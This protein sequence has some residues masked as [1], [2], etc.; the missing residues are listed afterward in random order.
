M[1]DLSLRS[2]ARTELV[3]AQ[4]G[5][6]WEPSGRSRRIIGTTSTQ[7]WQHRQNW[8]DPLKLWVVAMHNST[9]PICQ[10]CLHDSRF[11]QISFLAMVENFLWTNR[12]KPSLAAQEQ[13]LEQKSRRSR[14]NFNSEHCA[15]QSWLSELLKPNVMTNTTSCWHNFWRISKCLRISFKTIK[16]I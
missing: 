8:A 1:L 13:W 9:R 6:L 3:R 5:G 15:D 7:S 10:G 11:W 2:G 12:S 16:W 4:K 14:N